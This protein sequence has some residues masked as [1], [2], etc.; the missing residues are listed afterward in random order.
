MPDSASGEPACRRDSGGRATALTHEIADVTQLS[1]ELADLLRRDP[2]DLAHAAMLVARIEFPDL[3]IAPP[4][5]ELD[6]IGARARQRVR[7]LDKAPVR[8]RIEEVR[9]LVYVDE[10]FA[11]N[12]HHYDDFRNNLLN[13]VIER[14]LGVPISLAIVFLTTARRAGLDARG[15]SFPGH[16]LM[17][18]PADADLDGVE[19]IVLDPFDGGR[20]LAEHDCRALLARQLG[21]DAFRPD[22]LQPCTTRQIVSRLLNNLKRTY[23]N[24]RSF[25]HAMTATRVLLALDPTLDADLRDRGLLAYHLREFP[26]ALRDLEEYLRRSDTA[27][28]DTDERDQIWEHVAGLRRRLASMN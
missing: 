7:P 18:I 13:V 15:I 21:E 26:Q 12:V 16:F 24:L 2:E 17:R 27:H 4:L 23:V 1:E 20:E 22:M 19:A 25:P 14:R 28:E 6:A 11:P 9:R 10:G 5:A 8:D 3:D